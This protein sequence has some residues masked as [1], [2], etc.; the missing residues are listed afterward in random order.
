MAK[1][2]KKVASVDSGSID[3]IT[4]FPVEETSSLS[5]DKSTDDTTV[6]SIPKSVREMILDYK[7]KGWD[8]NRIAARFDIQKSIVED[9]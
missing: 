5:N 3:S 7:A 2:K 9:A 8:N 1:S 4:T 6:S